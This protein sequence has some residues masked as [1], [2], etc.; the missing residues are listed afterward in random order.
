MSRFEK[1]KRLYEQLEQSPHNTSFDD[2]CKLAVMVG[3]I[4]DRQKGSHKVYR[5]A[6]Y[7][8]IMNFQNINGKA[9]KY[10]IKQL[11]GFISTHNLLRE[12]AN[13]A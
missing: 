3:F 11:L 2:L 6:C 5:H 8:G 13:D 12:E 4:F 10:Q 7:P 9:N 1:L